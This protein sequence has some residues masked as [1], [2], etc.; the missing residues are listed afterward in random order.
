MTL[1]SPVL[2][3]SL[4]GFL[5]GAGVA[6]ATVPGGDPE[7]A[8]SAGLAPTATVPPP[9]GRDSLPD[10]QP[11]EPRRLPSGDLVEPETPDP[12]DRGGTAAFA[13]A[14]STGVRTASRDGSTIEAAVW[15]DD[16][17]APVVRASSAG[18]PETT[19]SDRRVRMWSMSKVPTAIAAIEARDNRPSPLVR[20]A[21]VRAL[22]RSE[23][24]RQR[25]VVLEVQ[26]A[27]GGPAGARRAIASVLRRAG[28]RDA[29]VTGESEAPED[30]RCRQWLSEP[31]LQAPGDPGAPSLL[32]GISTWTIADASALGLALA[33]ETLGEAGQR[34]AATMRGPKLRSEEL[35]RESDFTA[36]VDWGAGRALRAWNP[37]YKGGWGGIRQAA[38]VVGQFAGLEAGGHA[39]GIAIFVHPAKQPELDDPG[40][41]PGPATMESIMRRIAR[42]LP[43]AS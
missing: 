8:A 26:D 24:C 3:A 40:A 7:P 38:F 41:T 17:G 12:Q 10:D 6:F 33:R 37:A 23:N 22:Q 29:E 4:C 43:G 35:E 19:S 11:S 42:E 25:R 20:A 21:M 28:A 30:Q 36:R 27:A 9:V 34:V 18:G 5:L 31:E 15:R 14:L 39:Y 1:R 13:R 2:I 16:W 32:T